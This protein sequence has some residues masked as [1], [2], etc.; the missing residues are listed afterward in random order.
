[1]QKYTLKS[2]LGYATGDI[3]GGGAFALISL[4]FLHYLVS[5]ES[6]PAAMAGIIVMI[7]K[8]W[9]AISDPLMGMISDKTNSKHGRRRV[10][11]LAGILPV[12]ITFSMLWY[13]FG[14]TDITAKFIYYTI[15]Y[16]LFSTAFTIVMV[17]YNALLADMVKNYEDRIGFSTIRMFLSSLSAL[18]S[19]VL[20]NILFKLGFSYLQM[21]VTFGLFYSLPLFITFKSTWELKD[22][23]Q[24]QPNFNQLISQLFLSFKN[25]TY[26]QYLGIFVFGQMATDVITSM[27]IFWISD[28]IVK[29]DILS[30]VTALTMVIAVALLPVN[31]KIAQKYGK[32]F[33]AIIEQPFRV[34]GLILAF[35]LG[36]DAPEYIIIIVCTLG[37][38]GGSASSFVPWTL[39]PDLPDTNEMITGQKNAGIYAGMST[40]VRKFSSGFAVFIIGIAIDF[41]GYIE[42]SADV[43]VVQSDS[44]ILGIK[45][46]YCILPIVL[47][48]FTIYFACSFALNKKNHAVILL[49]IQTKHETHQPTQDL[50]VI[51]ACEKVSGI[52]FEEMWVGKNYDSI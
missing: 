27:L 45:I 29:N 35:F 2:K 4:L 30:L 16:I 26:R 18:I 38:I 15:A 48:L 46:L 42:S 5:V 13:S 25:R 43:V 8:F 23:Q 31:N 47:T 40:F 34:I 37:A 51:K 52:A 44:V 22:A 32:H 7:G 3:I 17:P 39:L 49:A 24:S 20:L 1:M 21:G 41:F 36:N 12:A 28:V 10:Y 50:E 33:P 6:I 9:D 14:L 19:V 11:L